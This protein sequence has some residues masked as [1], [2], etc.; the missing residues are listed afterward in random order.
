[1][2]EKI[3]VKIDKCGSCGTSKVEVWKWMEGEHQPH[4]CGFCHALTPAGDTA[5]R[6]ICHVGNAILKEIASLKQ[7]GR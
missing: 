7:E 6:A 2:S 5:V 3:E 1:M 4:L